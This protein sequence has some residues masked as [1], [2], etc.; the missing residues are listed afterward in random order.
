MNEPILIPRFEVPSGGTIEFRGLATGW[1]EEVLTPGDIASVGWKVYELKLPHKELVEV[2]GYAEASIN[3]A[4]VLHAPQTSEF[5]G[6]QYNFSH[7]PPNR[8]TPPFLTIGRVY[9]VVYT[10]T[11][12]NANE[13]LIILP[14]EME[15]K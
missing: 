10:L 1:G 4:D 3:P 12:N 7:T 5:T 13:Q 14:F 11:P 15:V 9:R 8:T 6:E 2:E